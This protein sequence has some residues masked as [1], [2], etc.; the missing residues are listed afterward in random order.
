MNEQ[1][2]KFST[3]KK[4]LKY[5][6]KKDPKTGCKVWQGAIKE[7]GYGAVRWNDKVLQAHRFAWQAYYGEIPEGSVVHHICSNS[8][9]VNIK[10]LQ[11]VTHHENL[12]EMLLRTSYINK[13]A[14]LESRLEACT[15]EQTKTTR[16]EPR[17]L[18]SEG[19]T[20]CGN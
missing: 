9:C 2:Q 1:T 14:E 11:I 12:A 16:H 10:H 8:S 3:P 5:Y 20:R 15:C 4:K 7:N 18:D 17:V 13:I 19:P 6:A